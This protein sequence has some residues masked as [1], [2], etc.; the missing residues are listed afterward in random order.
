MP[1]ARL[2]IHSH[3]SADVARSRLTSWL[4]KMHVRHSPSAPPEPLCLCVEDSRGRTVFAIG[5]AGPLV[6]LPLPPGT[7]QVT[8]HRGRSRRGYT[9]TLESGTS[10]DLHLSTGQH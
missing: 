3:D 8:A 1:C 5:D 4:G 9:L 10:F 7:Y 6:E 2:F